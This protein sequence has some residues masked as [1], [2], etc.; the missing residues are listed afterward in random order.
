MTNSPQT[1]Q[2]KSESSRNPPP[3]PQKGCIPKEDNPMIIDG[4]LM[5]IK[6]EYFSPDNS[7]NSNLKVVKKIQF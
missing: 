5:N 6:K 4:E 2:T 1:P 7:I 3:P